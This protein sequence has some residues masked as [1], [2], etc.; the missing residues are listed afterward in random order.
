MLVREELAFLDGAAR[1][2][3][4]DLDELEPLLARGGP[5]AMPKGSET[6]MKQ[7]AI[8]YVRVST[9]VRAEKGMAS[10]RSGSAFA[11]TLAPARTRAR[12]AERPRARARR[13]LARA[14]ARA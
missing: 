4:G 1:R 10:P 3:L 9:D 6:T 12:R 13:Y 7:R 2:F 5:V 11:P 8:G 14:P